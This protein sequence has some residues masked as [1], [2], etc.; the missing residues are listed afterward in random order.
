[1]LIVLLVGGGMSINEIKSMTKS[2]RLSINNSRRFLLLNFLA[3]GEY[4]TTA[5]NVKVLL[6]VNHLSYVRRF[7]D[8][9]IAENLILKRGVLVANRIKNYYSITTEGMAF[10]DNFEPFKPSKLS[11]QN[12]YHH[13]RVQALHI[14]LLNSNRTAWVWCSELELKRNN[15]L[16]FTSIP[17]ALLLINNR[18][19]AIELQRNLYNRDA[20]V[21]KIAKLLNDVYSK[22]ITQIVYVCCDNLKATSL[23]KMFNGIDEVK[24][25]R[26]E[27][28]RLLDEHRLHFKFIDFDDFEDYLDVGL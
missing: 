16:E 21:K 7:L 4:W 5:E 6:K 25:T 24:N 9:L 18:V 13:E 23:A 27:A 2:E 28:V 20:F 17:D 26:G 8:S 3:N 1:M 11:F 10:I 14:K 19:I 12:Q 15:D 22:R